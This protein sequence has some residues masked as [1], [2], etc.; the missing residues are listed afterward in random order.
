MQTKFLILSPEKKLQNTRKMQIKKLAFKKYL[1]VITRVYETRG[2]LK[3]RD[4]RRE[5]E[6][7]MCD[8][9]LLRLNIYLNSGNKK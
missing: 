1:R 9:R 2:K 8:A 4:W 3:T 6:S 7:Q 5:Q